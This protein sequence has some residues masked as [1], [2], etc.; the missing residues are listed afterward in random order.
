[1]GARKPGASE[2]PSPGDA[3]PPSPLAVV[4]RQVVT[5]AKTGRRGRLSHDDYA[6]AVASV[7]RADLFQLEECALLGNLPGVR[8]LAGRVKRS[9]F[10]TGAAIRA[11]LD[12]AVGEVELLAL[13]QRDTASQRIAAFLHLWYKQG[14][15]VVTAAE[16]LELS[17][18]YVAHTIQPR[19][20]ELVAKRFLELAWR[21]EASA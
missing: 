10:P 5:G 7:L 21:V 4:K 8:A 14:E 20:L 16:V 13:N 1:M 18:S 11:L 3:E 6:K 2:P 9:V 17:R 19:A 15:T 12:R